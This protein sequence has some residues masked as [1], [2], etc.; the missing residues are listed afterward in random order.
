[1]A[2]AL[3]AATGAAQDGPW[4][5]RINGYYVDPADTPKI[6][7]GNGVVVS[8]DNT[9][10]A[11]AGISGE[12][13]F[14]ERIGFELALL[15]ADHGD[16][17][18]VVDPPGLRFKVSDT[19]AMQVVAAAVNFHLTPK[20]KVDVY[21][22]PALAIV[23]FTNLH[24]DVALPSFPLPVEPPIEIPSSVRIEIES[25]L[26]LGL[27]AGIDVPLGDRGWLFNANLRYLM[28]SA[29]TFIEGIAIETIDY[30]P[31]FIGIGFGYRF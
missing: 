25:D 23:G 4:T 7:I 3:G 24:I 16:F 28:T 14:N 8:T 12:Y 31:L 18:I 2:S 27:N 26:G 22:G 1:L 9:S 30:D 5:L 17:A 19:L 11:G 13:R 6:T 10:G 29:D 20:A 15:A 21:V